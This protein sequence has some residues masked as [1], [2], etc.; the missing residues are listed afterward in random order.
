MYLVFPVLSI[1]LDQHMYEGM[2]SMDAGDREAGGFSEGQGRQDAA[3]GPPRDRFGWTGVE[4]ITPSWTRSLA[5]LPGPM[6]REGSVILDPTCRHVGSPQRR[7]GLA[8]RTPRCL[9]A[10][11]SSHSGMPVAQIYLFI[12]RFN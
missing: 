12:Q 11:R 5:G 1:C 3:L 8:G 4:S 10:A 9:V 2:R 6:A 7:P